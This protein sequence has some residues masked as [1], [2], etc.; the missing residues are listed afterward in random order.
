M[1]LKLFVTLLGLLTMFLVTKI[2]LA[3]Y[4]DIIFNS[5]LTIM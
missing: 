5:H 4:G 2:S 3:E 1:K